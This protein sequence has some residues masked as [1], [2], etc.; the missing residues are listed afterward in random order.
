[1]GAARQA[2]GRGV[3]LSAC[4]GAGWWRTGASRYGERGARCQV[5]VSRVGTG[6][7]WGARSGA[8]RGRVRGNGGRATGSAGAGVGKVGLT[9]GGDLR[10]GSAS[11]YEGARGG[12]KAGA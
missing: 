3:A 1:M 6:V 8:L 4:G 2:R 5:C 12:R 10:E 7:G 11:V 9:C